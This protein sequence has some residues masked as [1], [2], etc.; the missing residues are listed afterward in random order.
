MTQPASTQNNPDRYRGSLLGA[1]L[2][3]ALGWPQEQ[4]SGIIGEARSG[5]AEPSLEPR[6]WNR[7]G[8]SRHRRY[9]DPVA[10]GEYSDDTQL[11]LA[12]ARACLRGPRWWEHLTAVELPTWTVY[13]RGGGRAVLRAAASWRSGTAPWLGAPGNRNAYFR[14]GAN[15]AAMRAAPHALLLG[16]GTEEELVARVVSDA[17]TTHGH[18]RALVGAVVHALAVGRM[19]HRAEVMEYGGLVSW[20]LTTPAW[21][22][23]V[24]VRSALPREWVRA[25]EENSG[26]GFDTAWSA[27]AEE[28]RG[29]LGTCER[30]LER[31]ALADDEKTLHEL[32]CF[33]PSVNGAGTVTAAA[34]CYL[35]ERF[36]VKPGSGLVKAAF[37]N[38]ADTDTLASMT[39][40][41]LGALQGTGW[42]SG[43]ADTLQ[44]RAYLE[45]IAERLL[46]ASAGADTDAE[47]RP[48]GTVVDV[49][50]WSGE[51]DHGEPAAFPDGRAVS[52]ARTTV[53]DGGREGAATV[54]V[55]L[56]LGDGQQV[57]VDRP[58]SPAA[59]DRTRHT[60]GRD[61]EAGPS[62]LA[63]R[64]AIHVRDV[65]R[66][67]DF[68]ARVLG[69]RVARSGQVL[70][71][72]R[73][74]AF[75]HHPGL[76]GS[77]TAQVT[78]SCRDPEGVR[79]RL[80]KEGV[81]LLPPGP[82]DTAGS[83][84]LLDPDGNQVL[85][86]PVSGPLADSA[87]GRGPHG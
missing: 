61:P 32:G 62:G 87:A 83:L 58:A 64:V 10:A 70:Y 52:R 66:T 12:T 28:M 55:R 48:P 4:R 34:A 56:L 35:A 5:H 2:G 1:A 16:P 21:P 6:P 75:L 53:L 23:P 24:P 63:I 22:D 72:N 41:I 51:L 59:P 17:I 20:L 38:N 33:D 18:P 39:G 43:P 81:E 80:A 14:A 13:Q 31:S 37:L 46:T 77:G 49:D 36:A 15:G 84:R 54:R 25:F 30:S 74:L 67:R 78:V 68:Y 9:R 29:L 11:L 44:D 7:W 27:T 69:V 57:V 76:S 71:L 79:E 40:G 8:G 50:R 82:D 60:G 19:L 45:R 42:L 26:I 3:D 73:W 85:V 86:W 47:T 65:E